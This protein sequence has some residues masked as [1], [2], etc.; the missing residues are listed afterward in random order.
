MPETANIVEL[1][2]TENI[3]IHM[4]VSAIKD[5]IL[6]VYFLK[7]S[8]TFIERNKEVLSCFGSIQSDECDDELFIQGFKIAFW[9]VANNHKFGFAAIEYVSHNWKLINNI[10][11]KTKPEIVSPSA[12]FFYNFACL[13]FKPERT[14]IID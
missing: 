13:T 7:K 4:I 9:N 14:L 2:K 1:I 3:F 6:A 5:K 11:L 10:S 12:Y 8:N